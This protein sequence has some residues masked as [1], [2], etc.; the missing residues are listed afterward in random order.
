MLILLLESIF[1]F[2]FE[3]FCRSILKV[4]SNPYS[5]E[6]VLWRRRL[7]VKNLSVETEEYLKEYGLLLMLEYYLRRSDHEDFR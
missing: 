4:S 7:I 2:D 3:N 6:R 5:Y 1:S